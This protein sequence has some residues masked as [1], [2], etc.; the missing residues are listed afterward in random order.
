[1]PQVNEE[2][3]EWLSRFQSMIDPIQYDYKEIEIDWYYK[4]FN[5]LE[6]D[7]IVP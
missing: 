3:Q 4:D 7:I 6:K 1:M 2:L 5:E